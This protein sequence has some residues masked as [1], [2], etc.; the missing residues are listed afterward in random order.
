MTGIGLVILIIIGTAVVF[1]A[2][3]GVIY[4]LFDTIELLQRRRTNKRFP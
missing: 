3:I 4:K 1:T 2:S